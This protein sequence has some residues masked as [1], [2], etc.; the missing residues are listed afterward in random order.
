MKVIVENSDGIEEVIDS[1]VVRLEPDDVVVLRTNIP[2]KES[3]IFM[4]KL[5]EA[6]PKN[7]VIILPKESSLDI[8]KQPV[9]VMIDSI[10][11]N[12]KVLMENVD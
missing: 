9:E 7:K 4:S 12:R 2:H 10:V 11:D 3:Q 8:I 1:N 5:K 6:F